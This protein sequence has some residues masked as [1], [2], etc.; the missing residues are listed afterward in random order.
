M[1]GVSGGPDSVAL[2]HAIISLKDRYNLRLAV[3]HLNHALRRDASDRDAAFVERLASGLGL[4]C[5]SETKKC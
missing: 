2:L 4:D 5:Y 1:L 3:A